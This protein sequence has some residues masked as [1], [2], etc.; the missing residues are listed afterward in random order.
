VTIL[1]TGGTGQVGFELQR[2]LA[3][4][5]GVIAPPR[6]ELDLSDAR[7]LTRLDGSSSLTRLW[8]NFL[9]PGTREIHCTKGIAL[10]E[11][12]R[13]M[14]PTFNYPESRNIGSGTYSK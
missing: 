3:P 4:L 12:P 5:G 6:R 7:Q 9:K 10:V 1:V 2:A 14:H 8:P 11:Y 13:P